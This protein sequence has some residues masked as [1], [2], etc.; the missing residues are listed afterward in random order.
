M[1]KIENHNFKIK[2]S[3]T[4]LRQRLYQEESIISVQ[5][6]TEFFP[7]QVDEK[8]VSG[9]VDIKVDLQNIHSLSNLE[10]KT[11]KGDIG[12]V[13]ISVNNM[14]VW[15]HKSLDTFEITFGNKEGNDIS[16]SVKAEG[17]LIEEKTTIVSLYTTSRDKETLSKHFDLKDFYETCTER[18]IGKSHIYKYYA[19]EN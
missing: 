17:L 5:I 12:N 4:N 14:G 1:L 15:E 9:A 19:K 13:T 3:E 16:Y 7:Q 10:N 11:Y 6:M 18:E 8:I 2:S